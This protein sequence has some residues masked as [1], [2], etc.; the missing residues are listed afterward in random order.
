M[1]IE[2]ALRNSPKPLT[3]S[4]LLDLPD[5]RATAIAE[6]GDEV[7]VYTDRLSNALG[8]MWR[9]EVITRYPAP[10]QANSQARFMYEWPKDKPAA[11]VLPST[12]PQGED[13]TTEPFSLRSSV[14]CWITMHWLYSKEE[15]M[16]ETMTDHELITAAAKATGMTLIPRDDG[17]YEVANLSFYTRRWNPLTCNDDAFE[18]IVNHELMVFYGDNHVIIDWIGATGA[19]GFVEEPFNTDK[20]AA[21]RRAIVRAVIEKANAKGAA[22]GSC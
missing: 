5:V 16:T 12:F 1:A 20:H 22:D 2:H 18:L 11:I 15:N 14:K 4:E 13:R 21:T 10:E 17:T 19:T 7:R 8:L 9:R 6:Y 3:I